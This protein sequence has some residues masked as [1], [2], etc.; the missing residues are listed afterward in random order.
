M[1]IQPTRSLRV[2]MDIPGDKSISHRAAILGA[3]ARG[4]T[5]IRRFSFGRD[6]LSTVSCLR[7]LGVPIFV[8]GDTVTVTGVGLD[9]LMS[10]K[11]GL[12]CGN[13]G[14]TARLL[15]GMLAGQRFDSK[16]TGDEFLRRRPM[17]RVANPLAAMGARVELCDGWKLPA[18]IFG[19]PLTGT[20]CALSVASAQVKTALLLA[21]L[22]ARGQTTV[23]EHMATRDHTERLLASMDIPVQTEG[24]A[25][26]VP[27]RYEPVGTTVDVPGDFSSAAFFLV[28]GLILP[29]SEICVKQVGMNPTRT[30]LLTVLR[31]M[32]ASVEM[33]NEHDD[34]E[35]TADL[36][37]R[38]S[39]LRGVEVDPSLI[40]LLIDELPI[41]AVA[42]AMA[43]GD[44]VV[45]GAEELRYK[46]SDRIETVCEQLALAGVD[47]T[48]AHDGFLVR[49]G[50]RIRAA[51]YDPHGD[52]RV[53]MACAILALAADGP[54]LLNNAELA[55]VSFPGF[56]TLLY[57]MTR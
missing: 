17:D 4:D 36:I 6:T 57:R 16:I 34:V 20:V 44:T 56:G 38:T 47:I 51:R 43:E 53:A 18:L 49:G 19:R 32:G 9:G 11:Q 21:G 13:S 48:P 8:D 45:H 22:C 46:E 14:T 30:G 3:I 12:D 7:Q 41:L 40:P 31:Q 23:V 42:A 33:K 55:D 15:T 52:H 27:G 54:S 25:I 26:T 29:D 50:A 28:A 24:S 5:V 39:P 1:Q 2:N 35:P 37:V 10:T